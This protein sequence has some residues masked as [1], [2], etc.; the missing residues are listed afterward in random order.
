MASW[1]VGVEGAEELWLV[2]TA[3]VSELVPRF[4]SAHLDAG[5][6]SGTSTATTVAHNKDSLPFSIVSEVV[7]VSPVSSVTW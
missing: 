6:A 5:S 1:T 7:D 4:V 3:P 2:K